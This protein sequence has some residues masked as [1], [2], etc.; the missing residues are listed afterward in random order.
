MRQLVAIAAC[1]LTLASA[2]VARADDEIVRG[3]VVRVEAQEIYVNLGRDRGVGDG[4]ALRIKRAIVLH[5]PVTKAVV[6]DWIPIGS[7]AVT[8][9]G[10]VLSRA[11][12]G[13]LI[14]QIRI[15]DTVEVLIEHHDPSPQPAQTAT[16]KIAPAVDSVTAELMGLFSSLVGQPLDVRIT[17]WER[18]L[19]SHP[20]SPYADGVRRELEAMHSLRDELRA[21]TAIRDGFAPVKVLH[22]APTI[23]E[24]RRALALM[25]LIE[26]P[27]HLAS[28]YLHYRTAGARTFTRVLLAREHDRY[29]R[30]A[31]PAEAV[32]APGVEYF[33][34][35]SSPDGRSGL[36]IGSPGTP[37]AIDV[38]GPSLID[39]F[40]SVPGQSSFKIAAE[41]LSWN[42]LDARVGDR[43]DRL[44]HSTID[45]TYRL[46]GF[47]ESFGVGYGVY[48]G[49]GGSANQVWT[50]TSPAPS[51]AF[52]YG[53]ADVEVGGHA[54]KVHVSVGGQVIAG[55]DRDGFGMGGEGRI[56]IGERVGT[57]L[58]IIGR[59]IERVGFLSDIRFA[60]QPT[61]LFVIGLSVGATDQPAHGDIGV[62]LGGD[63]ELVSI[64]NV[65]LMLKG[66]WQGR[67]TDHAGLGG[68]A[69]L[70]FYW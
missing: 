12:V 13:D 14:D 32:R 38:S 53:Y 15:G 37:I 58:S 30:G 7:A 17:A 21:P 40:A 4:A 45:F 10:G 22:N 42:A 5:H 3:A 2:T 27:E 55:V 23:A 49:T 25:F 46:P 18:Y 24:P 57:S 67:S 26:Q 36:A 1:A 11:I 61:R 62:K 47:V 50:I 56:R 16:I 70:G 63:L 39:T 33:V 52:Q 31:I 59:S 19:S 68:G 51:T 43:T 66:S 29:L 35:A 20:G 28:A 48:A 65:S 64:R 9:A 34:E 54:D 6:E 41:Y 60:T 69:G 44:F 8:Q